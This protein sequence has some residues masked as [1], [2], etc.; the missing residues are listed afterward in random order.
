MLTNQIIT[1]IHN[2]RLKQEMDYFP[3][4]VGCLER[5]D[6]STNKEQISVTYGERAHEANQKYAD[7][8]RT[9]AE[10]TRIKVIIAIALSALVAIGIGLAA[11]LTGIAP[12]AFA[13]VP[14]AGFALAGFVYLKTRKPD[15]DRAE[16]RIKEQNA[17]VGQSLATIVK[18]HL[19]SHVI[20]YDLLS[21]FRP[22]KGGNFYGKFKLLA[23]TCQ[24]VEK[25]YSSDTDRICNVYEAAIQPWKTKKWSAQQEIQQIHLK[26]IQER[27]QRPTPFV[28]VFKAGLDIATEFALQ[29]TIHKCNA[30]IDKF[31]VE[32]QALLQR[33]VGVYEK[34]LAV[35]NDH[36]EA[37]KTGRLAGSTVEDYYANLDIDV[38]PTPQKH[39]SI[40]PNLNAP[41]L[42]G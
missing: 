30:E 15:L 39:V 3:N 18:K 32:K 13:A 11:F 29:N 16:I 9:P 6:S 24:E 1:D 35:L 38:V 40:Y 27:Q 23:K 5:H 37:L 36:F 19:P 42:M 14:F 22:E 34:A 17:V 10:K 7:G 33:P 21:N 31:E 25:Q 8:R 12:L 2:L 4:Y 41:E 20:D 26:R 28:R